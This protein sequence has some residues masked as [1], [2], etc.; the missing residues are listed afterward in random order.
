MPFHTL[1]T[2]TVYIQKPDLSRLGPYK[3]RV[4]GET[5]SIYDSNL[6][7]DSGDKL[8]RELPNNKEE[9][10]LILSADYSAGLGGAIPP[11]FG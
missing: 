4:S 7:V 6:D 3:T 9:S 10:Y 5:A 2:D 8:I 11:H 1:H